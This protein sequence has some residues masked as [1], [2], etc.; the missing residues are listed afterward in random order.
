M[1]SAAIPQRPCHVGRILLEAKAHFAVG[2]YA[3]DGRFRLNAAQAGLFGGF[4]EIM[5]AQSRR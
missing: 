1:A 5:D 4:V 3:K 2:H